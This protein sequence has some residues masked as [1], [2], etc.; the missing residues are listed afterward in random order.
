MNTWLPELSSRKWAAPFFTPP[1]PSLIICWWLATTDAIA[2]L[3]VVA[4]SSVSTVLGIVQPKDNGRSSCVNSA[5]ETPQHCWSLWHQ[6]W[7]CIF[8]LRMLGVVTRYLQ[9]PKSFPIVTQQSSASL[10][11]FQISIVWRFLS[12]G[13]CYCVLWNS[14]ADFCDPHIWLKP[15]F[16]DSR[17]SVSVFC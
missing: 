9:E 13:I 8:H 3:V 12:V 1:C 5:P 4:H 15:L 2:M 16:W 10:L 17:P 6:F 7:W 11:K 14:N